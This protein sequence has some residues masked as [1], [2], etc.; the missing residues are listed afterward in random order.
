MTRLK[1]IFSQRRLMIFFLLF[2]SLHTMAATPLAD[3]FIETWTSRDG[4]PHNS[5]NAIAQTDDG[6]LWFATWEG[7]ARYNGLD[8]K[9]FTRGND[10]FMKDSG[11]K[12]L[13]AL[14]DN[15]LLVAG[16]RG[17][18][19]ER[20]G[21]LWRGHESANNLVNHTLID[22]QG[23]LWLAIEGKGVQFR[24]LLS[25]GQFGPI[26][27]K[28]NIGSYRLAESPDGVIYVGTEKGLYQLEAQSDNPQQ[29]TASHF[30]RVY[31]LSFNHNQTLLLATDRGAW[32]WDKGKATLIT[33]QLADLTVTVI[34]QDRE[35]QLW[36]GTIN[37]GIARLQNQQL[38]FL[39]ISEGL[40]NN[41]VLS[42]LE[43][44]EGS[45][46]VGTNGGV[47]RLRKAP[48]IS[49]TQQKGL[50][51][52]YVRTLLALDDGEVL[53]GS[54]N[55]LSLLKKG[56]AQSALSPDATALANR[57]HANLSVLSLASDFNGGAWVGTYQR[58]LFHWSAGQLTPVW[59]E[60]NGLAS[61]EIR[62][63]LP[64]RQGN[65]WL[66]TPNG[67]VRR[68]KEGLVQ[69]F[70]K[71][72]SPLPG[73]F[74]MALTEDD[75]GQI[76]VGTGVGVSYIKDNHWQKLDLPAEEGAEYAFGFYCEPGYVWLA[77]DRGIARFSQLDHSI[78]ML[79]RKN[80]LP[81]DKFFQI[82][83]DNQGHFWL[84]SNRG[85]WRI[86]RQEVDRVLDG[87]QA[88]ISFEHFSEANGM[89]SSQANG[90]SNP[91]AIRLPDDQLLFATAKG[92][93]NLLPS[94]LSR[95]NKY[96]VPIVLESV[97]FDS[98]QIN[99][100]QQKEVP[101]EVHRVQFRY[102]GLSYVMSSQ[103]QYRTKLEGFDSQWA[104]RG[105]SN[106]AEYTN[107]PP[108]NY[109]FRVSV[110]YPYG[111]WHDTDVLY[112]FKVAPKFWQRPEVIL[113]SMLL[114]L[115]LIGGAVYWRIRSLRRFALKLEYKVAEQTQ[116]LLSQAD[117]LRAQS[118]EF[119]RL[120]QEDS[121]T[122]LANRR[123]FNRS[124][125]KQFNHCKANN[126][127]L[128][129]AIL[130]IDHFKRVNDDYSHLV[131]D[132]AIKA[133][134]KVLKTH[135]DYQN[136]AR[137]GGEEFTA[138]YLGPASEAYIHFEQLRRELANTDFSDIAEGL[139]ITVS[140]GVADSQHM[141]HYDDILTAADH[142]LLKAKQNGRN[143]VIIHQT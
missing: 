7:V 90:G 118:Q 88:L 10:T 19:A 61:N 67:L 123:A 120:A 68:S 117:A 132:Q 13:V 44:L 95:G 66:G 5:I 71:S 104:Y 72:N 40:P 137:W 110:R 139:T 135:H 94:R 84:S 93:A 23:N 3:Y 102:V 107:L 46:W 142:A 100:D 115:L 6:Y 30:Q 69:H 52:D 103:L 4:L 116:E 15:H 109:R 24:P 122:L 126:Q 129:V 42:W 16:A 21:L 54:S 57:H 87:K 86:Q 48:F 65:L 133:V 119:E 49:I 83:A 20:Q 56:Q 22:Q 128:S 91:A 28:L 75:Q 74:V 82:L 62:A 141:A 41:R 31:Y 136:I 108:G 134:A 55:G 51:G 131:G 106:Q 32:Y 11:V 105:Q 113:A 26:Q 1:D 63:I 35:G 45:I 50:I 121:L 38:E 73:N 80:G 60:S 112:D 18:V 2:T 99:P 47:I 39:D 97:L 77:T 78:Q 114:V 64:D 85:I 89:A 59:D 98:Q 43:D 34:E 101:A 138:L 8:F 9:L 25:N 140:I 96:S 130:D 33:P 124:I 12:S 143:R 76:W 79:G 29:L 14:A 58:G 53:V 92:V 81:N 37:K 27:W 127:L 125:E 70:T 36:L 17:S 111:K